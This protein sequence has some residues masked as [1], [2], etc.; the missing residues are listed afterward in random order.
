MPCSLV[1]RHDSSNSVTFRAELNPLGPRSERSCC[2]EVSETHVRL[3]G[4]PIQK[5]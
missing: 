2:L 3:R 1:S 4:P 5:T